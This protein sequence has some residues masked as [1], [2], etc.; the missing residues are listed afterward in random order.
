MNWRVVFYKDAQGT[1][2]VKQFILE[3]N[4]AAIGEILHVFDLLYKFDL[5]LGKPYVE[6]VD[7]DLW[8]LRIKHSSDYYRIFYFAN[9]G[10]KFV[11]LHAIKK[12]TDRLLTSDIKL[13]IQRMKDYGSRSSI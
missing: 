5:S 7:G 3:Q 1:E 4:H 10:R 8:A 11:L 12:K 13:A 6:K 2:P 9:T